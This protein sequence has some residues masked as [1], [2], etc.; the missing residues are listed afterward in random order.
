MVDAN[1]FVFTDMKILKIKGKW[2]TSIMNKTVEAVK[3][4]AESKN[5]RIF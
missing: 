2:R 1:I 5:R 4:G 3:K